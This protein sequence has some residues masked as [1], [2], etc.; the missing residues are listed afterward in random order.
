MLFRITAAVRS[1]QL[2]EIERKF[3][4]TPTSVDLLRRNAGSP[5]FAKLE[6]LKTAVFHD[7]YYDRNDILTGQ[8]IY[9]RQR[10]YLE[11]P[12]RTTRHWEAKVRRGGDFIKSA[13]REL[14][15]LEEVRGLVQQHGLE[16]NASEENPGLDVWA[17]FVTKRQQWKVNEQFLVVLDE[18]DFGHVVG[19]VEMV[20]DSVE[21]EHVGSEES[22]IRR[23]DEQIEEFMHLHTWA[24]PSGEVQGKL[25]AYF[26][27]RTRERRRVELAGEQ[28]KRV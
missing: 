18:A 27:Y 14:H 12:T 22:I 28:E 10:A 21:E 4:P 26:E 25:T 15:G 3:A 8:G 5:H 1:R 6:T 11:S 13:F 20:Q 7:T 17:R 9:V 19:E 16:L 23:L 2:L 24:F